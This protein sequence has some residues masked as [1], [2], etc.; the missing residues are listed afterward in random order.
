MILIMTMTM[1]AMVNLFPGST[2]AWEPSYTGDYTRL[3]SGMLQS[4]RCSR[5]SG[6]Q[7]SHD[8]APAEARDSSYHKRKLE[9]CLVRECLAWPPIPVPSVWICVVNNSLGEE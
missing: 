3:R 9:I 5:V 8:A 4:Q 2:G 1:M 6:L 7:R